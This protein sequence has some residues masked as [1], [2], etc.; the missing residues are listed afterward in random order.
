[1][2]AQVLAPDGE[3]MIQIDTETPLDTTPECFGQW[4]AADLKS[5]G[6][7]ELLAATT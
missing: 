7:L 3:A 1:M 6:A 5:R 4:V 2:F